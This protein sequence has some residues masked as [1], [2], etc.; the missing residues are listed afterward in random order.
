MNNSQN[1]CSGCGVSLDYGETV[2]IPESVMTKISSPQSNEEALWEYSQHTPG[3]CADCHE[4][5]IDSSS[6]VKDTI[7]ESSTI[8]N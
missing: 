6:S 5:L 7:L 4:R 2:P 3:Y 1:K 8:M